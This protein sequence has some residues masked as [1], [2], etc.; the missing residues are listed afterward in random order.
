MRKI[1]FFDEK[2]ISAKKHRNFQQNLIDKNYAKKLVE[3]P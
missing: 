1:E 3:K 2:K